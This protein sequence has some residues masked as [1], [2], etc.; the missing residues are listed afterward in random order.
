MIK[1]AQQ[2]TKILCGSARHSPFWIAC[3]II[4]DR[5]GCDVNHV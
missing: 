2:T 3:P 4:A 1:Y 5:V